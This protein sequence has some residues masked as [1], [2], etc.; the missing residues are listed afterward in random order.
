MARYKT[1]QIAPKTTTYTFDGYTEDPQYPKPTAEE[2]R[3]PLSTG[4]TFPPIRSNSR[5]AY[6]RD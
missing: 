4:D 6:W 3:I 5:G 1:G 2:M